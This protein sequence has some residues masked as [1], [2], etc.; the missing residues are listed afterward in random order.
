MGLYTKAG[1]LH[2]TPPF[3]FDLSLAF[4]RGSRPILDK[5]TVSDD[6]FSNAISVE[7][8]SFVFEVSSRGDTEH[9]KLGYEMFSHEPIDED[10]SRQVASRISGFLSLDDDLRPFYE[11]AQTDPYITPIVDQIYGY[12]QIRFLTPFEAACWAV[13]AQ[14][15]GVAAALTLRRRL[16]RRFGTEISVNG[17]SYMAF[18][19]PLDLAT[20]DA[21]E[22]YGLL[23]NLRR[24]EYMMEVAQAFIDIDE[25]FLK[26]ASYREAEAHLR[27][28]KGI[29]EWSAGFVLLRGIGRMDRLP[30]AEKRLAEMTSRTYGQ[31]YDLTESEALKIASEYGSHQGYWFHYLRA[32]DTLLRPS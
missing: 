8:Q 13:L 10:L 28:I 5:E 26:A 11:I 20:A 27:R 1:E 19:E 2:P 4:L 21:N 18:P 17:T 12:H 25:Q 15:N 32:A 24:S 14:R 30:G 23:P 29:G 9:P 3:D 6:G 31:G 7:G 22:L 16:V